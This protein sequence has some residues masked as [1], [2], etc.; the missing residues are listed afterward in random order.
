M[1]DS[2]SNKGS[3]N[4]SPVVEMENLTI[5]WE[6]EPVLNKI[7]LEMKQGERIAIIGPSGCGKSTWLRILAGLLLPTEG[8]LKLFGQTQKYLRLDQLNP[9]DVRF[10]F[11][12]PALLSSL[13]V[14]EN[15]GFLL[16]KEQNKTQ[17]ESETKSFETTF[18]SKTTCF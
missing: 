2:R 5:Q 12:N 16:R 9:P 3:E 8:N 18:S 13:T 11:Q 7:N 14:E 1:K 17:K 10:V 6:A 15:V 4:L